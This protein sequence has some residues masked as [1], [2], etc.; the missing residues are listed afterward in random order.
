MQEP[1]LIQHIVGEEQMEKKRGDE[2][3]QTVADGADQEIGSGPPFRVLGAER[4]DHRRDVPDKIKNLSREDIIFKS[5]LI[6][7]ERWCEHFKLSPE[8]TRELCAEAIGE[9]YT[10]ILKDL[11]IK[12]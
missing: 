6:F 12:Q 2:K 9:Y 10:A 7:R 4:P 5:Y 11:V 1:Y 8:K 3:S